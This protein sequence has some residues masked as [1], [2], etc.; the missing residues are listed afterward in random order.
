MSISKNLL[1]KKLPPFTDTWVTV[2]ENQQVSDIIKQIL[3][4]HEQYAW[5]YDKIALYF[6]DKTVSKICD[7]LFDFCKKEIKYN[8]EPDHNQTTALPTGI[9]TRGHGDCKHYAS[10]C[11]GVLDALKRKAGKDLNWCYRFVSYRPFSP[12]PHHVFVVVFDGDNEIWIDPTPGSEKVNPVWQL[13]KKAKFVSMPLQDN[14]GF[15]DPTSVISTVTQFFNAFGGDKVP[16]YPIKSQNTLKAIQTD[17]ANQIPMPPQNV[18]QA[19]QFLQYAL[20]KQ[21]EFAAK[22]GAVDD[23]KAI[24]YGEYATALQNFLNTQSGGGGVNYGLPGGY[25]PGVPG[26]TQSTSF[27]I[28]AIA[29]GAVWFMTKKP[30]YALGA[31]VAAW[32][33]TKP[34]N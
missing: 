15:V 20:Q 25:T 21:K 31:A 16:N 19:R 30:L 28:P 14:I 22:G 10:F 27:L 6:D 8:E 17:L 32:F 1:L 2:K 5:Y 34:K 33:L 13:D 18:D 11:G 24:M 23:T 9:L 26:T 12:S 4:A 7:R 29:G 3:K